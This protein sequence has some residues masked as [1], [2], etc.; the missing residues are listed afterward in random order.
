MLL[1]VVIDDYL[2]V[3][4][5]KDLIFNQSKEEGEVWPCLL[6]KAYAKLQGDKT[7]LNLYSIALFSRFLHSLKRGILRFGHGRLLWGLSGGRIL[8]YEF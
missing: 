7:K 6:E 5:D 8:S 1:Q 3:R 2:P 4:N